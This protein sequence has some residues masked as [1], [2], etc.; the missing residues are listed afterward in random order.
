MVFLGIYLNTKE[1]KIRVGFR[2]VFRLQ[3]QAKASKL[4]R[5]GRSQ[6]TTY[7]EIGGSQNTLGIQYAFHIQDTVVAEMITE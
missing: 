5:E 4:G 2:A 7:S 6:N 1:K 3:G